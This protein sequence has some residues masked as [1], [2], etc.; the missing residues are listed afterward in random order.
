MFSG[1][2]P[3]YL[4]YCC[5]EQTHAKHTYN[6]YSS[7][8]TSSQH[9]L[10]GEVETI[11]SFPRPSCFTGCQ[12]HSFACERCRPSPFPFSPSQP[13]WSHIW[14][15]WLPMWPVQVAIFS[16]LD[17]YNYL[18]PGPFTPALD[19][20]RCTDG[21][22]DIKKLTQ[23]CKAIILQLKIHKFKKYV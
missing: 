2:S 14:S 18:I 16:C 17:G 20:L 15:T 8:F 1:V 9:P 7:C 21:L 22:K 13:N 6:L 10:Q 19:P 3:R 23:Y 12:H 5:S 4:K 11:P